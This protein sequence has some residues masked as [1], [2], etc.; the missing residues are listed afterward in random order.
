MKKYIRIWVIL[1]RVTR[2]IRSVR[3]PLIMG[4]RELAEFVVDW[5]RFG[6][7]WGIGFFGGT[8]QRRG[9]HVNPLK[10]GSRVGVFVFGGISGF[11]ADL[12]R[13]LK[14]G[15]LNLAIFG[16]LFRVPRESTEEGGQFVCFLVH[17]RELLC[18]LEVNCVL[19][20]E[21]VSIKWSLRYELGTRDLLEIWRGASCLIYC[22]VG[23]LY[24][25]GGSI[26][27]RYAK[28]GTM[29]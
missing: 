23:G 10:R 1:K 27:L 19:L 29:A 4:R 5:I 26:D 18:Q 22:D 11:Y 6:K 16:V 21:E 28:G 24:W 3:G 14:W 7:I 15:N 2:L 8:V 12:R 25:W 20:M 17:L 9:V 13:E